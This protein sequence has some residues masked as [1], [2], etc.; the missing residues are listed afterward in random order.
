[1]AA[2]LYDYWR[3]SSSYRVRI[4]LNL[5]K[6]PFEGRTINLLEGE[7][8]AADYLIVNPQGFVPALLIDGETFTQSLAIIEY[9]NETRGLEI[10]PAAPKERARVRALSYAISMD[11]HPVCNISVAKHAVEASGGQIATERW[12][13]H[14][15]EKGLAAF[16]EML[17]QKSTGPLC[18]GDTVSMADICLVPQVYNARR[19]SVDLS[20][21]RRITEIVGL[22]EEIPEIAAA[23]PDY[24]KP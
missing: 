15:I 5:A 6:I 24:Y 12:M 18:H 4:A 22:L 23:H 9:L 20:G 3:S 1:M 16:E 13:R 19:W 2:V 10:L 21:W 11:L 7:Q 8:R 17:A 14:F